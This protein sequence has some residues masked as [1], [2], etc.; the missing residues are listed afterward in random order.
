MAEGWNARRISRPVRA[1]LA[2]GALLWAW[3]ACTQPDP[4]PRIAGSGTELGNVMGILVTPGRRPASG[5]EVTLYPLDGDSSRI[6]RTTTGADGAFA[7]RVEEG[8]FRLLALDG[9]GNGVAVDSVLPSP[10]DTIDLRE[11]SLAPQGG[12]RGYL[13]SQPNSAT[14]RL[15]GTWFD[16]ALA[17]DGEFSW[18][19]IPAGNYRLHAYQ[20]GGMVPPSSRQI[21]VTVAAGAVTVLPDTLDLTTEILEL[22]S[23]SL[24]YRVFEMVRPSDGFEP[25]SVYWVLNGE[26]VANQDSITIRGGITL[27]EAMLDSSRINI[28]QLFAQAGD[29]SILARAWKISWTRGPG[30]PKSWAYQAVRA[31]MLAVVPDGRPK[32]RRPGP[33]G[34]NPELGTFRVLDKR[35]LPPEALVYW[36]W[37]ASPG[38]DTSLPD[39]IQAAIYNPPPMMPRGCMGFRSIGGNAAMHYFPGD[40]VTFF[41]LPDT[42]LGAVAFRLRD[43]EGFQDLDRVGYFA[44]ADWPLGRSF[45]AFRKLEHLRT[46]L[47]PEGM[48]IEQGLIFNFQGSASGCQSTYRR[49]LV[50]SAGGVREMLVYPAGIAPS[51]LLLHYRAEFTAGIDADT[52]PTSGRYVYV[53]STGAGVAGSPDSVRNFRLDAGALGELE[54]LLAGLPNPIPIEWE[55]LDDATNGQYGAKEAL[56]YLVSDNRG[57][58]HVLGR[59]DAAPAKADLFSRVELWLRSKGLL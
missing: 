15:L 35:V 22:S 44:R 38:L 5:V 37:P 57:A 36:E 29:S 9:A 45:E 6:L 24:P 58:L 49:F 56:R 28:L 27:T 26:R 54:S 34:A 17:G 13:R 39:E 46:Y 19:G 42:N 4:E 43:D 59:S 48:W 31:V 52:L 7:F 40:T 23:Q 30:R 11:T 41:L 25:D 55:R 33:N 8:A 10:L 20:T 21:A 1:A 50:D 51:R 18:E 53:D 32:A 12:I 14:L 47:R 3:S 2:L 16:T